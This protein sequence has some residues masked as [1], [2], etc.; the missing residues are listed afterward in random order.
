MLWW[1]EI[2]KFQLKLIMSFCCPRSSVISGHFY[3]LRIKQHRVIFLLQWMFSHNQDWSIFCTA[4]MPFGS[5]LTL[6]DWFRFNGASGLRFLVRGIS[7]WLVVSIVKVSLHLVSGTAIKLIEIKI[8]QVRRCPS[9]I[10]LTHGVKARFLRAGV[11]NTTSTRQQA[12]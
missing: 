11:R 3:I 6:D 10:N 9:F 8:C 2:S 5:V 1:G 7:L 12:K 4:V